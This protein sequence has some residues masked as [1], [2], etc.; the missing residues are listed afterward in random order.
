MPPRNGIN[1]LS[2]NKCLCNQSPFLFFAPVPPGLPKNNLHAASACDQSIGPVARL[3]AAKIFTQKSVQTRRPSAKGYGAS[4]GYHKVRP[5]PP[6]LPSAF[7]L[8]TKIVR[9]VAP[10]VA[11]RI[12]N[13]EAH[14]LDRK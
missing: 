5:F 9:V 4:D 10:R 7:D 12:A 1:R 8:D 2:S 14:R 6:F 11:Q 3:G 13:R